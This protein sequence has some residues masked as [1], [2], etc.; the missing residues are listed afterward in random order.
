MGNLQVVN[1]NGV[2]V[3]SS[4]EVAAM[5]GRDHSDLMKSIRKYTE[6][7][8]SANLPSETFFLPSEYQ[9]SRNQKQPC[10][11]LTK[12]GCDMVA[13][14]MTGEKGIL[15]TAAYVDKFHEMEK[16]VTQQLPQMTPLQMIHTMTDEMI[17]QDKRLESLED[18]VNNQLTLDF[19]Q[20]RMVQNAKNKRVYQLWNNGTIN[21]DI[22][23][24]L[25]KV[26]AAIGRDL[27]NAFAV[28]SFRDIRKHEY[29][30]AINYIN[31]WRPSLV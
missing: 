12:K 30:E 1:H 13:N 10:F 19:G 21:Q 28:N 18:K 20:Q 17:K 26:H 15:F 7:L 29:E 3:I 4:V 25:P 6:T 5:V 31:A 14:K 11:L 9:N 22:L 2:N 23:D 24:T 27:K 8:H 16:V